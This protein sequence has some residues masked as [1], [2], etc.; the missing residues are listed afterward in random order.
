MVWICVFAKAPFDWFN[1]KSLIANSETG[2]IRGTSLFLAG[3]PEEK[4]PLYMASN[5]KAQKFT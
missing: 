3:S 4:L 1:I 2:S 5:V